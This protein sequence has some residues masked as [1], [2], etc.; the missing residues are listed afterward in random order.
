MLHLD[1]VIYAV[2]DLEEASARFR[3]QFGLPVVVGGAHPGGTRNAVVFCRDHSYL[4]LLA[5]D[6]PDGDFARRL[7]QIVPT[8][9]GLCGWAVRTDD[10]DAVA[11][12]L[13]LHVREGS[14]TRA[15]GTVGTWRTAASFDPSDAHLPFVIQYA[16]GRRPGV[17]PDA[18]DRL[19]WV[20]VSGDEDRMREWLGDAGIDA[21]VSD[22]PPGLRAAAIATASGE[23]V[24]R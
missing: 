17:E 8:G 22:G 14:I 16:A 21:R 24:I 9:E 12:R 5:V 13:G 1:H 4:E 20:E 7:A 10:I 11:G 15:D 6:D 2:R 3:E 23:I 18:P 19:A